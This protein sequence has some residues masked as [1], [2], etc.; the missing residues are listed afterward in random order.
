MYGDPDELNRLTG[1]LRQR[2]ARIRQ[3][4]TDHE[5]AGRAARRVSVWAHPGPPVAGLV[6]VKAG[7][8]LRLLEAFLDCPAGAGHAGEVDRGCG[9]IPCQDVVG[10]LPGGDTAAG[11]GSQCPGPGLCSGRVTGTAV[12]VQRVLAGPVCTRTAW[13][14]GTTLGRVAR[15]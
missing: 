13:T 5:R 4:A 11:V 1:Q 12:L 3:L 15:R 10:D 6:L 14:G 2:A 7:L 8:V 9:R